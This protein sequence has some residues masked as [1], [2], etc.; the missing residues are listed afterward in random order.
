MDTIGIGV[1]LIAT[2]F[3]YSYLLGDNL[4]Y[5]FAVHLLVG[6]SAGYAA[7]VVIRELLWPVLN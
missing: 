2:I 3:V 1:G 6:V 7:V 5:R 4:L